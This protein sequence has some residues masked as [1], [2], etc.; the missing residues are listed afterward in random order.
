MRL[1]G[2]MLQE[3]TK[4]VESFH[5]YLRYCH[6]DDD[7]YSAYGAPPNEPKFLFVGVSF[8]KACL[9]LHVIYFLAS[10]H[11]VYSPSMSTEE[12]MT[13]TKVLTLAKIM[14]AK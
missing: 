10:L 3:R 11:I 9:Y 14:L 13:C 12:K 1:V 7:I 8:N 4:K 6:R 2:Q 5:S